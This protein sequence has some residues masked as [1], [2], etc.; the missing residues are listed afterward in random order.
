MGKREINRKTN[1]NKIMLVAYLFLFLFLLLII[2]ISIFVSKNSRDLIDNNYN[3]M[4]RVLNQQNIRGTIY[5][6][7][8]DIL[9]Q[10]ITDNEIEERVYPYGDLFAHVVGYSSM[11]RTGIEAQANYYLINSDISL[12]SKIKNEA[13]GV[14]NPG[15]NVI[16]TLNTSL[17]QIADKALGN[18]DGAVIVT[19]VSTGKILAMVSHPNF[20]PNQIIKKWD[21]LINDEDSSLLN[22]AT[23]GLYPPG[24]TFKIITALEYIRENEDVST[25]E[26]ECNG[27]YN[28]EGYKI[29]CYHGTIHGHLDFQS[30]FAKSCNSSFANIGMSIDPNLFNDTLDSLLFGKELPMDFSY[31]KS[32]ARITDTSTDTIIQTAIGQGKTQI[33]PI[34]LHMITSSIANGGELMIPYAIDYIKSDDGMIVRRNKPTSYGNLLSKEESLKLTELMTAVVD[35]GTATKLKS[36]VYTAAGKTG[37]AEYNSKGDSHAWFTGFA[38]ATDPEICITVIVEGAGTGGEYAVPI[39]KAVFDE[40]FKK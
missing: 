5:S 12:G 17:Q 7:N 3:P 21:V 13:D 30:S 4:Q 36:D 9:A 29:S 23:Q 2:N 14:K 6:D 37:S 39:A 8:M 32:Y 40:Y 15:N 28:N 38:P 34:H 20:D 18:Y 35:E 24:S 33:T 22:R 31:S 10:T 16:T 19:E 1:H 25:Y 26:Y 27:N 11:G